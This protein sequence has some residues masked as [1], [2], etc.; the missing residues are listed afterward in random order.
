MSFWGGSF[1]CAK[2]V[3]EV[4]LKLRPQAAHFQ[5]LSRAFQ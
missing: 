4:T 5:R 2:T 1:R 3:S